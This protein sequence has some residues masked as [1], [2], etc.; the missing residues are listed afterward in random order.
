MDT[1]DYLLK[2]NKDLR[3]ELKKALREIEKMQAKINTLYVGKD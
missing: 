3:S 2:E 1:N